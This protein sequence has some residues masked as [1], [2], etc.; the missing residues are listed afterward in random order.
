[1][2]LGGADGPCERPRVRQRGTAAV[3]TAHVTAHATAHVTA[4]VAFT[5]PCTT[6][7]TISHEGTRQFTLCVCVFVFVCVRVRVWTTMALSLD[8]VLS[9]VPTP[10]A[11]RCY[12]EHFGV[13]GVVEAVVV[14]AEKKYAFVQFVDPASQT[15]VL[16]AENNTSLVHHQG[17]PHIS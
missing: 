16:Q 4:H 17:H 12:R 1:M 15:A 3:S 9:V 14:N 2:P 11:P 5:T 13:F 7:H 10:C 6:D 8:G